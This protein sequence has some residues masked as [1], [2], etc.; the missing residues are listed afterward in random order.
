MAFLSVILC[1]KAA[2]DLT[3]S[4]FSFVLT[5]AILMWIFRL[6]PEY[7][8]STLI[9]L[10]A[11]FLNL[12]PQQLILS[13]FYSNSFF[14]ALTVF[15]LG[16]VISK[17]RLFYRFS[18]QLLINIPSTQSLLE[19]CLFLI[20]ALMTPI[21]SVQSSRV[22]LM[23]P[24]LDD[25]L[26]SSKIQPRSSFANGLANA[27]FNGCILLSTVFLTGKS[28]NFIIYSL[29]S[30]QNT[31]QGHWLDWFYSA[32]F[33]GVLM[34]I[35]FFI[36]QSKRFKSTSTFMLNHN[37]LGE[38]LKI[39]G[40]L[41]AD[42]YTALLCLGIFCANA[43]FSTWK[44]IDSKWICICIFALV[45]WKKTLTL[46]DVKTRINWRFLFYFGTILGVMRVV[47]N[48]GLDLW[49]SNH[50]Q[51]L[52]SLGKTHIVL[53]I[54]IIYGISWLGGLL[55]GTMIAP[56]LL[57]TALIPI[58][59]QS[60]INTWIIAFVILMATEA[61]I[62]PYQSSYFLCFEELLKRKNNF[63]MLPLLKLNA[64]MSFLK[65]AIVLASI[66]FWYYLGLLG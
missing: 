47:Q 19:K 51:W 53:F 38:E 62:F 6:V 52:S 55:L 60:E 50:F 34:I 36:L 32:S 33:S 28:S 29:L 27:A 24:L 66:P 49:F 9:I 10:A 8:P 58:A 31:W 5:L 14:R 7:V 13:G 61:W 20:G 40:P 41:S 23:A 2:I 57:F 21:M 11:L 56:A 65:L 42:E 4:S 63:R 17:S 45:F 15:A 37:K 1:Q 30:E 46:E 64:I 43:I 59:L 3:Y 25:I 39:L 12:V 18:I 54:I 48:I 44:N 16:V 35:V 26:E 22:A